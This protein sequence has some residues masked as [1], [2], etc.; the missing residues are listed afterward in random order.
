MLAREGD[1][2]GAFEALKGPIPGGPLLFYYPETKALRRDPRFW[3]LVA[4]LGLTD[5]W[6]KSGHWPDFCS[7]PDLGYDCRKAAAA[8]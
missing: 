7:E 2:D 5:Y 1:V 4:R 3:P 6:R 8:L